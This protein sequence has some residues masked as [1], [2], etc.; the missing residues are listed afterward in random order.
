MLSLNDPLQVI[1]L[2]RPFSAADIA[3]RSLGVNNSINYRG[4]FY[5]TKKK[6]VLEELVTT[7]K[8]I[9]PVTRVHKS[10]QLCFKGSQ[11]H[12]KLFNIY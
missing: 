5:L 12:K 4:A 11:K 9:H 7:C 3:D 10:T 2:S 8:Q 1:Y 6:Q